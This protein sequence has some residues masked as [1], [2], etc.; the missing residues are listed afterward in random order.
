[1]TDVVRLV[2][3]SVWH[4]ARHPAVLE[5]WATMLGADLLAVCGPVR[6]EILYSARS[7]S[8]YGSLRAELDG[9]RQIDTGADAVRRAEEVQALLARGALHH[10]SVKLIDLLVAATAELASVTVWHYDEDYDRISAVT[11][12]PTVWVA[13][14]GSL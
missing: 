2:D 11:G 13:R 9:L 12:Q 14:R 8:D 1:M 5:Q 3:T 10:R 6:L 7:P 4:R